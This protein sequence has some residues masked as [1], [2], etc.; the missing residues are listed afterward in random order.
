MNKEEMKAAARLLRSKKLFIFDLDGTIYLGDRIFPE[1]CEFIRNLR[2]DGRRVLFF[3]NNASHSDSFYLDKLTKAGFEPSIQEIMT[4]GDVTASY[5]LR[6]HGSD[7]VY[8]VG[9][10]ELYEDFRRRGIRMVNDAHGMLTDKT[11]AKLVVTSFD[12]E[13][14]FAKLRCAC[15]F[16]REGAEY[17]C[18]HPDY[19]C[20]I[21]GGYLPDSGAIAAAVTAAA[22]VEPKFFGKPSRMTA[23]M[24]AQITGESREDMC[25][26]GDRLYTDIAAGTKNGITAMLV[27]TGKSTRKEAESLPIE[28][29]PDVIVENLAEAGYLIF[30]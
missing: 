22:G 3:T 26:V 16:I 20:P 19:N 4:S 18:T 29:R 8:L 24:I 2:S 28:D 5:I 12:T 14:S 21:D 6:E 10:T 17:L 15:D 25:I 11:P 23:D 13:F 1:A 7:P 30:S 27:L 9:S